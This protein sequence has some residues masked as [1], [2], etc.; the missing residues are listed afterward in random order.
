MERVKCLLQVQD[1]SLASSS[2]TGAVRKYT[3]PF[4]AVRSL[5]REGGIRS[6]YRGTVATL[7]RDVPG[8]IAY[9]GAYEA[10][11]R[12]LTR[13]NKSGELSPVAVVCAGGMAGIANWTVAIPADVLKSRLQTAPTGQ[14]TGIGDVLMTLL[15]TDGPKA[16]FRGLG[17][18]MIRAF[19]ANAACFLGVEVS[20][21]FMNSLC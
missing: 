18:A 2:T 11:K 4:D 15:R 12:A 10:V 14:Y 1:A 8:S 9:F 17:P 19:P 16:L 7:I 3:G 5:L 13:N 6:L 20:L 21:K